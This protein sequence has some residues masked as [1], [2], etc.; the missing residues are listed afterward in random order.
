[1]RVLLTGAS[2]FIGHHT[3]EA[4]H[5]HGHQIRA[6]VRRTSDR[7][8]FSHLPVEIAE[9]D[10]LDRASLDRALEGLDA[11]VHVAG[12]TRAVTSEDFFRVN[13]GGTKNVV[14]AA[15]ARGTDKQSRPKLVHVSSQTVMGPAAPG[16]ASLEAD[17]EAP[18][19]HYGQSKLQGEQLV[20]GASGQLHAVMIRPPMVYGPWDKDILAA[21][22]LA[23]QG[24]GLWLHPGFHDKR[25]S[26]VHGHDLGL[27]IVLAL[28]RGQPLNG[29]DD[30][31]QGVYFL[32]DGGVYTYSDLGRHMAKSVGRKPFILP[33]PEAVT[34]AVAMAQELTTLVTH[35]A[36]LLGFDKIRDMRGDN[37]VCSDARARKEL[38][39]VSK[40]DVP[41]G[42]KNTAEWYLQRGW[43]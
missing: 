28:E 6:L 31:G 38:G 22:K 14:E 34:T 23:K 39:Y 42:F 11:V 40:Y 12:I 32:T 7:S 2:G 17:V 43:I 8:G 4:L 10:V 18:L 25:Y 21:F 20:R 41:V 30:R 15:L 3:A 37:Y 33:V 9:G 1:V 27:G 26:I 35:K 24:R 36:P 13:T 16:R 5:A 29:G 19:S